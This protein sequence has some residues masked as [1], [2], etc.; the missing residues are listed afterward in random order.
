MSVRHRIGRAGTWIGL[1]VVG[2]AAAPAAAQAPGSQ[3]EVLFTVGAS[4]CFVVRRPDGPRSAADRVERMHIVF[5]KHLGGTKGV[6]TMRKPSRSSK[7]VQL[8]LNGDLLINV[9]TNDARATRYE[10]AEQVAP[11]W[12][13]ALERA[14]RETH[15]RPESQRR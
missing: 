15:A 4:R 7:M 6:V 1:C 9:T 2:I 11:I 8:Y 12:K 14:F 5:N 10:R 3:A 13:R